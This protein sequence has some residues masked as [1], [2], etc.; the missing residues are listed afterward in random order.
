M[1]EYR[2]STE[3]SE[4]I[5]KFYSDLEAGLDN[6]KRPTDYV[7]R[8]M[9]ILNGRRNTVGKLVEGRTSYDKSGE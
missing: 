1:S 9:R 5:E 2:L 8:A 3:D 4:F 6:Y 7:E